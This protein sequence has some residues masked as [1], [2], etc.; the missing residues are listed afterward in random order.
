MTKLARHHA[1]SAWLLELLAAPA[2]SF[3][4]EGVLKQPRFW[5][6]VESVLARSEVVAGSDPDEL[7]ETFPPVEIPRDPL[8][9]SQYL[10]QYSSKIIHHSINVGSPRCLGHMTGTPPDFV[11]LL[12]A[13]VVALNQNLGK[14]EASGAAALAERQTLAMM[15]RLTFGHDEAFYREHTH[16]EGSTLGVFTSGGTLSNMTA[17]WCARNA[18]LPPVDGSPGAEQEGPDPALRRDGFERGVVLGSSLSHYS[19]EKATGM[20]GLGT[21]GAVKVPVDHRGRMDVGELERALE[22]CRECRQRV[23]AVVGTA[24]TTECGSIDPLDAIAR[25]AHQEGVHFHVDAAWSGSFLLSE[26]RRGMLTGIERADSVT[27]DGHKQFLLPIGSSILLWRDPR[28]ALAIEKRADYM[29]RRGSGDLGVSSIEGSR[30][31]SSLLLH[32]VLHI[33]GPKGFSH[34]IEDNL[35]KTRALAGLIERSDNF[36][37]LISPETNIVVYRYVPQPLRPRVE[38]GELTEG[39]NAWLNRLNERIQTAQFHGGR[40]YT[41]RTTLDCFPRYRGRLV[42]ALRAVVANPRTTENDL[43][44]VLDDQL[45]IAHALE[46]SL[47]GEGLEP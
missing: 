43:K 35:E 19:L 1:T 15:H 6:A 11:Q 38:R 10:T 21:R 7:A 17:L 14:L 24:G 23:I 8:S 22:L 5:S 30:P 40:T 39:E 2:V 41:S 4:G 31:A 26:R 18:C 45:G 12:A 33:I 16:A 42:V 25:V 3:P 20:L 47:A 28:A 34:L 37:L 27:I 36:E 44:E 46:D 9:V 32:A 29:L 13:G